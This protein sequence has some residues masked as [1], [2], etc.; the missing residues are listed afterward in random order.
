[1]PGPLRLRAA[2][3]R[4]P[5]RRRPAS[6]VDY[7]AKDY[8]SFRQ[9]LARPA[10]AAV[11]AAGPSATR[12]TSAITLV[13]L[14]AYVGDQLSYYQD[15]VATE[16]YLE[17][18]R[19]RISVRRHARLVDYQMHD[20]ARARAFVHLGLK[21][22]AK[23][24]V[25]MPSGRSS[26]SPGSTSRSG[27]SRQVRSSGSRTPPQAVRLADAVFETFYGSPPRRRA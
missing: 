23:L 8:A 4:R 19:Q 27:R 3:A 18:A 6:Q 5:S 17:T 1:M 24:T 14:L 25:P 16:A 21:R 22:G 20:G 12:P 13:E 15:A 9:A 10:P 7:L 11:A 2:A 26:S